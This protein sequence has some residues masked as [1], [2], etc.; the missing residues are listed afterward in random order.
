MYD[1]Q[2]PF[3][4]LS[5][6]D[7]YVPSSHIGMYSLL[8]NPKNKGIFMGEKRVEKARNETF[9]GVFRLYRKYGSPDF[10]YDFCVSIP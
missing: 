2:N 4:Y 6:R 9:D 1:R 10:C 5:E 8:R 3:V 7:E